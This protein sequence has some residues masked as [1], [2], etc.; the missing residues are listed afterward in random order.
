MHGA[1]ISSVVRARCN[2]RRSGTIDYEELSKA[3]K[4]NPV[5][6]ARRKAERERRE[7]EKKASSMTKIVEGTD[8][9][10]TNESC[11]HCSG[12]RKAYHD[13]HN[14]CMRW[15]LQ[16]PRWLLTFVESVVATLP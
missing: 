3:L 5:E 1:S 10:S 2:L 11:G 16:W 4:E 12:H 9:M 8:G 13:R 7:R 15:W 14:D 6:V